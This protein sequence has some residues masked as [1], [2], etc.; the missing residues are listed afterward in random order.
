M[1]V[2][3]DG[4][5]NVFDDFQPLEDQSVDPQPLPGSSSQCP[6]SNAGQPDSQMVYCRSRQKTITQIVEEG[7]AERRAAQLE[8]HAKRKPRNYE[9]ERKQLV[10]DGLKAKNQFFESQALAVKLVSEKQAKWI[11]ELIKKAE[12]QRRLIKK[13]LDSFPNGC[14]TCQVHGEGEDAIAFAQNMRCSTFFN[15]NQTGNGLLRPTAY[16]NENERF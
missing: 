11:D 4:F 14:Q 12:D 3:D 15:G 9:N 1:H 16:E 7:I 5:E 10:L 8:N 6:P 2:V 13:Q